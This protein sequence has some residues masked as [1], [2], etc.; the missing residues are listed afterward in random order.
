MLLLILIAI[1]SFVMQLFLPWWSMALS[2]MLLSYLLGKKRWQVLFAGFFGCGI[3]WLIM[4]FYIHVTR[5][6]LMTNRIAELLSLH[7][8]LMLYVGTFLVAAIVG[9]VS[10]LAGFFFKE[11]F[12]LQFLHQNLR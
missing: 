3:V 6:D 7:G 12:E 4:A 2:A 10:A 11:I 1:A 8:T 5:G 9:G